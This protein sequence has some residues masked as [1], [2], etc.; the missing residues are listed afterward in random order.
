MSE[1]GK[2]AQCGGQL[3]KLPVYP[4]ALSDYI[5]TALFASLASRHLLRPLSF[6]ACLPTFL[7]RCFTHIVKLP[8]LRAVDLP[9]FEPHRPKKS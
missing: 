7:G 8:F 9:L 5:L 1:S 4:R 6:F 2:C 3:Y